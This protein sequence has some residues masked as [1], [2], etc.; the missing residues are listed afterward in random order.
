MAI[1]TVVPFLF[2]SFKTPIISSHNESEVK[3]NFDQIVFGN[4]EEKLDYTIAQ[5]CNPIP[6]DN[7]FGFLTVQEGIKIH[8]KTCSNA[9]SLQSKFAYR[10]IK[11]KW[12]DSTQEDF[13]SVIKISGIDNLGIVSEITRIISNSLNI[14]IKKMSFDTEENTFIGTITLKVK[15]KSIL[16]KL[17]GR[18]KKINGIEKVNR[19]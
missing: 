17:I 13:S 10:I 14:N 18:L 19:E 12:I 4:E 16:D 7:V 11:S 3:N 1:K 15:T 8:K 5:C 6:G 9:I 2:I